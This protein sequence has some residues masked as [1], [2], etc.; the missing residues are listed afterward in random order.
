MTEASLS[1]NGSHPA[2][3]APTDDPDRVAGLTVDRAGPGG[4]VPSDSAFGVALVTL[5]QHV[6]D[7]GGLVGFPAPVQRSD[8]AARAAALVDEIRTGRVIAVVA[9][10][11]HRL[12]GVALL[13]PGRGDQ[14]HTGRIELVLV[15]PVHARTGIGTRL[16]GE[17]LDLAR[18]RGLELLEIDA[19]DGTGLETFLAGFGFVEWGRRPGWIRTTEGDRD[20][21]G[22]GMAL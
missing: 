5:W 6:A 15:E 18:E 8:V 11:A 14:Q 19:A 12:I 21:I 17:L 16:V 20:E 10:R 13:R 4:G 7:A 22:W 9:N 1:P 2:G 3:A